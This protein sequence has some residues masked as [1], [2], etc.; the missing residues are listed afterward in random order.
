MKRKRLLKEILSTSLYILAV[1]IFT[2]FMVKYVWQ[3]IEVVGSSM[4]D[5]LYDKDNIIV[6]KISYRF[7][8]PHRF[9][10]I[11]FPYQYDKKTLYVK[12]I[13]GL[14]GET[15]YIDDKG[16]IF[17]N[18]ILLHEKYGKEIIAE[19]GVASNAVTLGEDEYFV[20]GDNRNNSKDSRY[21]DVG[22]IK[23][24]DIIG[25]AWILIWPLNEFGKIGN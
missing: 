11:V 15:V 7:D 24:G 14:P 10:I 16:N 25:K 2:L 18:D 12:R 22:F 3:R 17:I 1:L 4:E 21:E 6:E 8:N 9:D 20:L 23:R 19:S 5:T 13:I